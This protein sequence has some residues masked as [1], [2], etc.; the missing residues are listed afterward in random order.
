MAV[1]N[2]VKTWACS[3]VV[4]GEGGGR[5]AAAA[6]VDN[7]GST[8]TRY[9]VRCNQTVAR[10]PASAAAAAAACPAPGLLQEGRRECLHR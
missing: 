3:R 8:L 4:A 2:A 1:K 5:T 6:G 9:S 7:G 10:G